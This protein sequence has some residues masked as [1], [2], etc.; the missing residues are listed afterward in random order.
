MA[1]EQVAGGTVDG[2]ADQFALGAVIYEMLSGKRAFQPTSVQTMAAIIDDD[3]EPLIAESRSARTR[4]ARRALSVEERRTPVRIDP[5]PCARSP[6]FARQ[7]LRHADVRA[8]DATRPQ[9]FAAMGGRGSGP[10]RRWNDHRDRATEHARANATVA[11]PASLRLIAI[12]PFANV[13]KDPVDQV[14]GDG[15]VET[16]ASSLTQLERFQRTL[17]VVPSSESRREGIASA[18]EAHDAFGRHSRSLAPFSAP[19]RRCA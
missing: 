15:L 2:R 16:L 12:V 6:R 1:P 14:F 11:P 17:R 19:E 13:T 5:R 18:K 7:R 9:S 3:P 4:R 10:R 8:A